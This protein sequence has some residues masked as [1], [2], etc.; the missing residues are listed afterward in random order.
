[1]SLDL[2]A[3]VLRTELHNHQGHSGIGWVR[4][5]MLEYESG[6]VDRVCETTRL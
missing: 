4:K 6:Y 1:M 3:E 2:C 5:G